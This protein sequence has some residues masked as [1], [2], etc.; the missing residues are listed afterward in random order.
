[1]EKF[2]L[3]GTEIAEYLTL[4]EHMCAKIA[5]KALNNLSTSTSVLQ[6]TTGLFM[7]A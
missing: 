6:P 5:G 7:T 2:T 3:I 4:D 1:L